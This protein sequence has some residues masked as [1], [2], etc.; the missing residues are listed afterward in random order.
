ML[1]ALCNEMGSD[2]QNSLLPSEVRWLSR[3]EVLKRL[4]ELRKEVELFLTDNKSDLSHYFQDK[5]WVARLAY[6]IDIFSYINELNLKLQVP[7]TTI[8]N[9]W[10]KSESFKKKVKLCIQYISTVKTQ[11]MQRQDVYYNWFINS[12]QFS[13]FNPSITPGNHQWRG[14]A[15][16]F[17]RRGVQMII[18]VYR[19][20]SNVNRSSVNVFMTT[21]NSVVINIWSKH[22]L[23][24]DGTNIFIF[25]DTQRDGPFQL[26]L[27]VN[28]I[29]EGYI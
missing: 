5:K 3:G 15:P 24:F 16:L 27:W 11:H 13:H 10:N 4:Y 14:V 9:A 12:A 17:S 2:H 20:L 8:F 29:A 22:V 19:L 25:E 18:G 23:C 1:K 28:M 6:L 7:D 26:K 21:M